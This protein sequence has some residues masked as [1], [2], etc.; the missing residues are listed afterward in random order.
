MDE[1]K[2]LQ[3]LLADNDVYA[4]VVWPKAECCPPVSEIAE[5]I[6]RHILCIPIDQRYDVDDME[7]IISILSD[8]R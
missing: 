8:E 4:P 6:Y 3:A 7:R 5:S 1:R 2:N